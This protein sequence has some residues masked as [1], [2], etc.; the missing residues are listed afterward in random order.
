M[1]PLMRLRVSRPCLPVAISTYT[2][3]A[4]W[5]LAMI[6]DMTVSQ[7]TT[8]LWPVARFLAALAE[9]RKPTWEVVSHDIVVLE[10]VL[11]AQLTCR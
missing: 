1:H 3:T 7:N 9:G 6:L 8:V 10:D 4:L 11:N 5:T 2:T